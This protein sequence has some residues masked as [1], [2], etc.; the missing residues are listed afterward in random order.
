MGVGMLSKGRR[1]ARWNWAHGIC[2]LGMTVFADA[3]AGQDFPVIY[4]STAR[5]RQLGIAVS[6]GQNVPPLKNKCYYYGDGGY[7][8]SVSD[9]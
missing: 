8:I 3:A 1:L 5:L 9:Q 4:N 7:L 6:Y 2:L